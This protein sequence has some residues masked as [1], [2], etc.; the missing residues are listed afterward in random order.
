MSEPLGNV[1]ARV[2]GRMMP[3]D[4]AAHREFEELRAHCLQVIDQQPDGGCR[5][6]ARQHLEAMLY[7][8]RLNADRAD[9][10]NVT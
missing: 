8:L 1:I 10:G 5:H 4:D 2:L 9:K 7:W 3:V 6:M